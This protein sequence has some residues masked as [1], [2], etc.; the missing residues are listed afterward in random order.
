[1]SK[2]YIS[3]ALRELV[4]QQARQRRGYCLTQEAIVGT[5]M[6]I[7]HIIPESLGG[8]TEEANL[9]LAC[10]LCND[11][12]N[13]RIAALDPETGELVRLFD[14]R[15]QYWHEHFAWNASGEQV[16]GRQYRADRDPHALN[17]CSHCRRR[18]YGCRY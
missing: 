18:L 12:K 10:S 17:V 15:R 2:A 4:S 13:D 14:P 7:D 11:H 3:K 1:V 8:L 9:W 16:L 5:S 6:E